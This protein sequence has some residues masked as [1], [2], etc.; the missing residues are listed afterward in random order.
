MGPATARGRVASTSGTP[1]WRASAPTAPSPAPIACDGQGV[2]KPGVPALICAPY[3]CDPGTNSCAECQSDS[4]CSEGHQC[5][6][7]LCV[8]PNGGDV[9]G[10]CSRDSDCLTGHCADGV[11]CN[12][13][14]TGPCVSCA[15]PGHLGT[16][17]PVPVGA[18]DPHGVCV[19]QGAP[20]CGHDGTCDGLGG[21]SLYAGRGDLRRHLFLLW[22]ALEQRRQLR[23]RGDLPASDAPLLA[24]RLRSADE[25]LP[26]LLR[27]RGRLRAG[28]AVRERG[29]RH[30]GAGGL[31]PTDAECA[32]GFCAQGACCATKCD[33]PCSSCALPGTIGTCMP[34]PNPPDAGACAP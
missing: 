27:H 12:T 15:L 25:R 23:R 8:V 17:S 3:I 5:Q 22:D 33:G 13:A 21:C 28:K 29:L 26:Q 19:D 20:S 31:A 24:V 7:G 14:C 2:C 6:N 18:R 4:Q 30:P 34:V 1:A 16:C 10:L 11:C 9:G 32:S